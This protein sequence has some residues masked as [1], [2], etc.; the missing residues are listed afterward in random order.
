V[1]AGWYLFIFACPLLLR[2]VALFHIVSNVSDWIVSTFSVVAEA[3]SNFSFIIQAILGCVAA[4]VTVACYGMVQN[5]WVVVC[6][7]KNVDEKM[8]LR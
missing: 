1:G 5:P 6:L 4:L 3:N 8:K 2:L 7:S